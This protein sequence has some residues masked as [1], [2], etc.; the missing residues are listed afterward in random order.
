MKTAPCSVTSQVQQHY[1]SYENFRISN[2]RLSSMRAPSNI[3]E[4]PTVNAA[5]GLAPSMAPSHYDDEKSE[6]SLHVKGVGSLDSTKRK[7]S[8]SPAKK[9]AAVSPI[10]KRMSMM[11]FRRI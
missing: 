7:D 3:L 10:T 1:K 9:S 8:A 4:V 2:S 5:V 11:E 6:L